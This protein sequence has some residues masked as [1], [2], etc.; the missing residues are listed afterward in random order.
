MEGLFPMTFRR[1]DIASVNEVASHNI[2]MFK[3]SGNSSTRLSIIHGLLVFYCIS[4]SEAIP[5]DAK[6]ERISEDGRLQPR[7]G[8]FNDGYAIGPLTER[9]DKS[10]TEWMQYAC[11]F[12]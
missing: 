6:R 5:F 4:S 3:S 2:T 7:H 1:F 12:T 11:T 10:D 9:D 8:K